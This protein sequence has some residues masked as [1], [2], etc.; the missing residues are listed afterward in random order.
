MFGLFDF[1]IDTSEALFYTVL[2]SLL[3]SIIEL[4]VFY[5]QISKD[6]EKQIEKNL[7][8]IGSEENS[9]LLNKMIKEKTTDMKENKLMNSFLKFIDKVPLQFL[10]NLINLKNDKNGKNALTHLYTTIEKPYVKKSLTL[11]IIY[12]RFIILFVC[13]LLYWLYT[14]IQ[15]KYVKFNW[16]NLYFFILSF[17]FIAGYQAFFTF[18]IGLAVD[19]KTKKTVYEYASL[20]DEVF[21]A[22]LK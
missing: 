18:K 22:L 4:G 15:A 3:M 10:K 17:V 21:P 19:P 13:T 12:A 16:I 11:N 9:Q 6:I 14:K 8:N 5:F 1:S 20:T 7:K 2:T